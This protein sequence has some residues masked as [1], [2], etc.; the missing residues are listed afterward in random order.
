MTH[1]QCI[2]IISTFQCSC[3]AGF[4]NTPDREGCMDLDE[5]VLQEHQCGPGADCFNAPGSYH[6]ACCL[7][8][9]GDSFSCEAE[10]RSLCPGGEGFQP[11][12][13]TVILE[14]IDECQDLP[15]LCWGGNCVNLFGSFQCK[16]PPGH[17]LQE[18]THICEDIDECSVHWGICGP[19]TCYNTLGNYMCVC[20]EDYL[21]VDSGS[22]CLGSSA[23]GPQMFPPAGLPLMLMHFSDIDECREI[24]TICARGVCVNQVGSFLCEYPTGFSY[25]NVDECASG[26][27]SCQQNAKCIN[28]PGSY[29][30][31]CA[32]GYKLLPGGACVGHECQETLN[33]CSHGKCVDTEG[34]Y[35][36]L[37]RC[38][39]WASADQTL[40]VDMDEC[41]TWAWLVCIFG[42][43]LNTAGSFHYLCQDRFELTPNEKNCIDINECLSLAGIC[44]SGTCQNLQGF[45][46]CI[47]PPSFQVQNDC[48]V[49]V[50]EYLKEP[51]LC[52]SG[53]C[54]NS[55]GSFQYLCLP[56]FALSDNGHC[57]FDTQQSFCFT[58]FEAGRC[59]V[60]KDF[61]TTKVW[62]CCSQRPGEGRKD[63]C[64]L[65]PQ[66]GS[67]AFQEPC[68]FG[69]GAAPGPDEMWEDMNE[70]AE[71]P[72]ICAS[73]LYVNTD[74]SFHCECPL[75]CSLDLISISCVDTDKC[76]TGH[77]CGEG[78]YT[79]I[80]G[81]FECAYADGFEPGPM[82]TCEDVDE[83]SQAPTPCAFVYRNMKGSFLCAFP[84][85]YL[86]EE[87]SRT[88]R[89]L[90]ECTSRQHNC[91]FFCIN[92]IGTFICCCP[93][94][95]TQHHQA[96]FD[97]ATTLPAASAVTAIRASLWAAQA[98]AVKAEL[99][100]RWHPGLGSSSEG[101][102]VSLDLEAL[103]T[104]GL[105]LS[106][107]GL[108]EHTLELQ[109]AL[110][111]LGG[112]VCYII[113]CGNKQSFFHMYHFLDLS[114]LQLG[115]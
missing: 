58:C 110:Q 57:C 93:S 76:F 97:N 111:S 32:Q 8:F 44:L 30:C 42:Q 36:C 67:A 66:E 78:T 13:I 29:H 90:D 59:L 81:S 61:N 25:N 70:C 68:P 103:L 22:N 26:E 100:F 15:G 16:C 14:D 77:P 38:G 19:G 12:P 37:C 53:A 108:A 69:H 115:H 104:L 98:A 20:P 28:I 45:F 92:T 6:C 87:D 39:S 34:G 54:T 73:G 80:I 52:L 82:M 79:N 49:N 24:P 99:G 109:P 89:D 88:C 107:L 21:Q 60:L 72:N 62:Y 35:I 9:A 101:P 94:G 55:P 17:H 3:H 41:V 1:S 63:P 56:G 23:Q 48:Y 10:Y 51:T 86:L 71:N 112:W 11:N 47:C 4:Q 64:E 91:K 114:S 31:K 27:S 85:G 95:F 83:C 113:A 5:C 2:N 65:C 75:G 43:C 102:W 96:C 18:G 106:C 46:H 33:V 40:C 74:C 7:G 105:N 50:S 84:L